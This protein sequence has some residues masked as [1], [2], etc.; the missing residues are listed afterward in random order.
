MKRTMRADEI[1]IGDVIRE[2]QGFGQIEQITCEGPDRLKFS[3]IWLD[4]HCMSTKAPD[5]V[6][7]IYSTDHPEAKEFL[8]SLAQRPKR[9]PFS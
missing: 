2:V 4:G 5:A 3:Y 7:T 1:K 9:K 8:E 6:A